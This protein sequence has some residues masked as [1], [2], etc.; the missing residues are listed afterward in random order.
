MLVNKLLGPELI[1]AGTMLALGG[2]SRASHKFWVEL[3]WFQSL[4][5]GSQGALSTFASRLI[6]DARGLTH[7]TR[8]RLCCRVWTELKLES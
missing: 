3:Q 1:A 7:C 5:V 2:Y 8:T 4:N 6:G